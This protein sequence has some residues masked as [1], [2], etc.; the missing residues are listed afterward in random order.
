[1]D[2]QLHRPQLPFRDITVE[3]MRML[4]LR[5]WGA[6]CDPGL[7]TPMRCQQCSCYCPGA[8]YQALLLLQTHVCSKIDQTF[9]SNA[10]KTKTA[11]PY[12]PTDSWPLKQLQ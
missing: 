7:A 11:R 8:Q 4:G 12:L 9:D 3:S 5:I 1:M 2:R 6:T 10:F